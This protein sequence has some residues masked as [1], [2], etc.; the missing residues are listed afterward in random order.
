MLW[1]HRLKFEQITNLYIQRSRDLLDK[2][3]TNN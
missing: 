1:N 2:K 3:Q